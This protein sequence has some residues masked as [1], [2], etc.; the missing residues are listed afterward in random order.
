MTAKTFAVL[1]ST[2]IVNCANNSFET[3]WK[4]QGHL[5]MHGFLYQRLNCWSA[6][7]CRAAQRPTVQKLTLNFA[8]P[9]KSTNM[10]SWCVLVTSLASFSRPQGISKSLW[11]PLATRSVPR[12]RPH[13]IRPTTR[14]PAHQTAR[15]HT[16]GTNKRIFHQLFDDPVVR[17]RTERNR[18]IHTKRKTIVLA[19][20]LASPTSLHNDLAVGPPCSC[21]DK[22]AI[23]QNWARC[24]SKT[25]TTRIP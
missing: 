16:F 17:G 1:A 8:A 14:N 19:R 7:P 24:N 6:T 2:G 5:D 23:D 4:D 13:N 3:L 15:L 21:A 9:R 12:A 20:T 10:R 18:I 11:H 25:E 22:R